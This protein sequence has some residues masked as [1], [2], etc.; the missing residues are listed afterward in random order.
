MPMTLAEIIRRVKDRPP[1]TAADVARVRTS[2]VGDVQ[3]VLRR[4]LRA[5]VPVTA[6]DV[7]EDWFP[8]TRDQRLATDPDVPDGERMAALG[9]LADRVPW[10]IDPTRNEREARAWA[11]LKERAET[12]LVDEDA[13]DPRI[14]T[15]KRQVLSAAVLLVLAQRDDIQRIRVGT[16]EGSHYLRDTDDA[17][18]GVRPIN[19][20]YSGT[21][22]FSGAFAD[23][24]Y[25]GWFRAA[26]KNAAMAQLLDEPYPRPRRPRGTRVP[27]S[28]VEDL[29]RV[30]DPGPDPLEV[31]L[32]TEHHHEEASRLATLLERASPR[33]REIVELLA[34]ELSV[35]Q[36]AHVLD[37]TES[38]VRGQL[39]RLRAKSG[40][41]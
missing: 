29:E 13:T 39:H 3:G 4:F 11:A 31:L 34:E 19:L 27:L 20:P 10:P 38:T 5:F 25:F 18:V 21:T 40:R 2:L 12:L 7:L 35:A 23:S 14:D 1:P 26:V 6:T 41:V 8:W 15:V 33:Q 9:R 36:I 30:V 28:S 17:P 24:V 37:I 32:F 16:G 22:E